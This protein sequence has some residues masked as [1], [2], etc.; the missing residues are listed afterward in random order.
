[1]RISFE[2][3]GGFAGIKLRRVIDSK[4][5]LPAEA[6]RLETLL[7]ESRFYELPPELKATSPGID[8]F[9][10]RVT[11]EDDKTVRTVEASEASVPDEM[12]PLID[13]L[14]SLSRH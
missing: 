14:T 6:T 12:R 5:L 1:M 8:R 13:W 7:R 4:D 10:Y 11:V 2:R 3:S 9:H